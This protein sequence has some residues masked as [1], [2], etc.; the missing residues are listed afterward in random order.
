MESNDNAL[1]IYEQIVNAEATAP[2]QLASLITKLSACDETGQYICS[3]ARYLGALNPEKYA[4]HI[5][6]LVADAI[7][8]DR[9]HRYISQLLPALWGEDFMDKAD[10]L[11]LRDN[12]FR[13]IFKR[14]YPNK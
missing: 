7:S 4:S 13:R 1:T 11:R 5:E 9:E 8:R 2:E 12:N 3:S 10:E 14:I 6:R